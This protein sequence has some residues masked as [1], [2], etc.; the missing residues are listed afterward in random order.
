MGVLVIALVSLVIVAQPGFVV[1]S[2]TGIMRWGLHSAHL[3]FSGHYF[4][5]CSHAWLGGGNWTHTTPPLPLA[6]SLVH[7]P[8]I[9]DEIPYG[10]HISVGTIFI[11]G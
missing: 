2:V 9:S 1:S 7:I 6:S 11:I 4:L 8:P 10:H 3:F 5:C